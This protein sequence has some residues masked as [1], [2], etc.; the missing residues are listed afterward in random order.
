[1]FKVRLLAL[2]VFLEAT[3]APTTP[4]TCFKNA[5]KAFT[6]EMA[7]CS[8]IW[9]PLW[10]EH[11][12]QNL[13]DFGNPADATTSFNRQLFGYD[14]TGVFFDYSVRTD[15]LGGNLTPESIALLIVY[16]EL[17]Q[18]GKIHPPQE[19]LINQELA[20]LFKKNETDKKARLTAQLRTL[21]TA[22]HKKR[23]VLHLS[24][25]HAAEQ[26]KV[27]AERQLDGLKRGQSSSF[28]H[29]SLGLFSRA[30]REAM[31]GEGQ[32]YPEF[33]PQKLLLARLS[34]SC[35]TNTELIL[36]CTTLARYCKQYGLPDPL[37]EGYQ[38]K[39]KELYK[40]EDD[41]CRLTSRESDESI[42]FSIA[43][44]VLDN[45]EDSV[46]VALGNKYYQ[47]N[48]PPLV[49]PAHDTEFGSFMESDHEETAVRNFWNLILFDPKTKKYDITLLEKLKA[50]G[51]PVS[52]KLIAFYKHHPLPENDEAL[53]DEWV[54]VVTGLEGVYYAANS[55]KLV[56]GIFN[57]ER[58][59]KALT[60]IENFDAF[61]KAC[62]EQGANL[63]WFPRRPLSINRDE[64][65]TLEF[66]IIGGLEF[67]WRFLKGYS[68]VAT[69][70]KFI[71]F[72]T[73]NPFI[74]Q[75]TKNN[76]E[77]LQ[78]FSV[79]GGRNYRFADTLSS[80]IFKHSQIPPR[81][82]IHAYF[83]CPLKE[84]DRLNLTKVILHD[85]GLRALP[86]AQRLIL[87][88]YHNHDSTYEPQVKIAQEIERLDKKLFKFAVAHR[89][90]TGSESSHAAIATVLLESSEW[91]T[92]HSEINAALDKLIDNDL[93]ATLIKKII[94]HAE[95]RDAFKHWIARTLTTLTDE[96]V[97]R[98]VV[99]ALQKPKEYPQ[100]ILDGMNKLIG[101]TTAPLAL[102]K[103]IDKCEKNLTAFYPGI[104]QALVASGKKADN[105]TDRLAY[106]GSLYTLVNNGDEIAALYK[107]P[108]E[109]GFKML[110]VTEAASFKNYYSVNQSPTLTAMIESVISEKQMAQASTLVA[111]SNAS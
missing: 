73:L 62:Q 86:E 84:S 79:V 77:P 104:S 107:N 69:E 8:L 48:V 45:P 7:H 70:E 47:A 38:E 88:F 105:Y 36:Y 44:F 81:V 111:L 13:Y 25:K 72:S 11:F 56:S 95:Q 92:Y 80:G 28:V 1:M 46:F 82:F 50:T 18:R 78:W 14:E 2:I 51:F 12:A 93:I 41:H 30:V 40:G 29:E 52:D 61:V 35:L 65:N 60:G 90:F 31:K 6:K 99:G 109:K 75:T 108:L 42:D 87:D 23:D 17:I 4:I 10:A 97:I 16:A 39:L 103:I 20:R 66:R 100:E 85:P 5:Y 9:G 26:L 37:V 64:H 106:K 59:L 57:M 58:V 98:E 33:T 94:T 71:P 89:K 76:Q 24:E 96:V 22:L 21:K 54:P 83:F 101:K 3:L 67:E 91:K 55:F 19:K 15:Q 53:H 102:K 49:Q 110:T 27:R 74:D 43:T 34:M 63:H 32:L 68:E